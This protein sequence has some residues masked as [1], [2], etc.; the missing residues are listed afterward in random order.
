MT[1]SEA[2]KV[3]RE[4]AAKMQRNATKLLVA[5]KP[6]MRRLSK[7]EAEKVGYR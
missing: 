4:E 6:D 7:K 5:L 1:D 3:V 2:L